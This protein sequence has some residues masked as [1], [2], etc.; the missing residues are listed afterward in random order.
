MREQS[1]ETN[2]G[3]LFVDSNQK[4]PESE[5]KEIVWKLVRKGS[6]WQR[7]YLIIEDPIF[8]KS[9]LRN[10]IQFSDMIAYIINRH[11]KK[12]KQ[13]EGW[14]Q[15]LI[16]KMYQPNGRLEDFGIKEFPKNCTK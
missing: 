16:S 6:M 8:T 12:D 2:N 5:I 10:M 7:V 11:Y 15:M 4:I 1:S 3:L 9:H 13:F 14:F